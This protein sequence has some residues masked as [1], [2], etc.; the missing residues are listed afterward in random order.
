LHFDAAAGSTA[1]MSTD[2]RVRDNAK[3]LGLEV[4]PH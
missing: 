2:D 3:A 1:V 4:L